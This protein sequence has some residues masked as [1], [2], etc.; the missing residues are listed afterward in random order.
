LIPLAVLR[1]KCAHKKGAARN[2]AVKGDDLAHPKRWAVERTFGWINRARRL[3]KD[4]EA[5]TKSSLAWLF[6]ALAFLLMRRLARRAPQ[7][8]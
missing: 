1:G 4:F 7:S 6:V 2:L 8:D 3:A 5:T